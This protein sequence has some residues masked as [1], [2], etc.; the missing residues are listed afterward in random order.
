MVPYKSY[1]E[2]CESLL[3]NLVAYMIKVLLCGNVILTF[4]RATFDRYLAPLTGGDA[5][6]ISSSQTSIVST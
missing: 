2:L 4:S 1:P 5:T 3:H 6:E